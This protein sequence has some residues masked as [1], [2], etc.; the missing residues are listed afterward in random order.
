VKVNLEA[1]RADLKGHIEKQRASTILFKS[2]VITQ[3][4][5]SI[6]TLAAVEDIDKVVDFCSS[7]KD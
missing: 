4:S 7:P 6:S 5:Q 1:I 3:Y 2:L